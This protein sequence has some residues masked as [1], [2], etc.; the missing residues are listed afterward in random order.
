VSDSDTVSSARP[1]FEQSNNAQLS[2]K[3]GAVTCIAMTYIFDVV[4][5]ASFKHLGKGELFVNL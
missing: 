2:S 1:V 4:L 5:E 3:I